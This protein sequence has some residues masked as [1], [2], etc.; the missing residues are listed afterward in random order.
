MTATIA[1][2]ASA[3]LTVGS[4]VIVRPAG[5]EMPPDGD[6]LINMP[7]RIVEM[8]ANT[9]R[10]RPLFPHDGWEE[11]DNPYV[12]FVWPTRALK[13]LNP[14]QRA[15]AGTLG[16][17][18]LSAVAE[19]KGPGA[20]AGGPTQDDFTGSSE[21]P[22]PTPMPSAAFVR[23]G[24]SETPLAFDAH[25]DRLNV[26]DRVVIVNVGDA[27]PVWLGATGTV[28]EVARGHVLVRIDG[29]A[30]GL[31]GT[32]VMWTAGRVARVEPKAVD[33]KPLS[34]VTTVPELDELPVG[35]VIRAGRETLDLGRGCGELWAIRRI[36]TA[37]GRGGTVLVP[38]ERDAWAVRAEV[39]ID[40]F[41]GGEVLTRPS[42]PA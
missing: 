33:P 10:L 3:G 19:K 25:G 8:D 1:T 32:R 34:R 22:E 35:T 7:A 23:E 27:E 14:M 2:P 26:G 29:G 6:A 37:T 30:K 15:L 24:R 18:L 4:F 5:W 42:L 9:A 40:L 12:E 28:D 21:A 41:R 36:I 16:L 39:F 38:L 13:P 31:N 11:M 20:A 17:M